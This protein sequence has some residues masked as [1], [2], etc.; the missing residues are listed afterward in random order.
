[1]DGEGY[2]GIRTS[3]N[4][5]ISAGQPV[6]WRRYSAQVNVTNTHRG[7]LETG[8]DAWGR[9]NIHEYRGV[10]KPVYKWDIPSAQAAAVLTDLLPYLVVKREQAL[11]VVELH[12]RTAASV[13][14]VGHRMSDEERAYRLDLQARCRALNSRSYF[15]TYT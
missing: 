15:G 13:G 9:G 2:I 5:G 10:N 6:R 8:R 7:V 3:T 12:A 11:L 1:M 14:V 4:R